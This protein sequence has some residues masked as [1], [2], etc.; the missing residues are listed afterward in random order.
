MSR[1]NRKGFT[2]IE[3]VVVVLVLGILA[4]MAAPKLLDITGDARANSSRQSLSIVRDAVELYRMK[5]GYYPSAD[6]LAV[7]VKE[8]IHGSFP[9][10]EVGDVAGDNNIKAFSGTLVPSGTQGWAFDVDAGD[11]RINAAP[12]DTW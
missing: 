5:S 4:A 3:L 12:Y 2:L 9:A 11:F 7:H 6:S 1:R 10:P 8:Y